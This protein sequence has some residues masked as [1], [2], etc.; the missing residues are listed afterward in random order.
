MNFYPHEL[1]V[2][3]RTASRYSL[4]LSPPNAV[5]FIKLKVVTVVCVEVFLYQRKKVD[6]LVLEILKTE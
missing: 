5:I 3:L 4:S 2:L 1:D 6:Q